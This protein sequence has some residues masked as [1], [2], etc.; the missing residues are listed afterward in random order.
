LL[1]KVLCYTGIGH[2]S[3]DM[4]SLIRSLSNTCSTNQL[5]AHFVSKAARGVN[6]EILGLI[7]YA[8]RKKQHRIDAK[9][10]MSIYKVNKLI[11]A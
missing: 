10:E 8:A 11:E 6:Q 9:I 7:A 1:V 4:A 2:A 3:L 5:G